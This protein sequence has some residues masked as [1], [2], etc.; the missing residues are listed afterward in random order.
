VV[1]LGGLVTA[2]LIDL[3]ILPALYLAL[4]VV[5]TQDDELGLPAG[6]AEV[7]ALGVTEP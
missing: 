2:T 3:F 5:G 1:V 6:L 4:Q 7:P